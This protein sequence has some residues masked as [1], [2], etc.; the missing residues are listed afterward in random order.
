[1]VRASLTSLFLASDGNR[2]QL[3]VQ[4][5]ELLFTSDLRAFLS[6]IVASHFGYFQAG[7]ISGLVGVL[8]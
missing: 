2:R 8:E 6:V 5:I 3:F 4:F 7:Y 1:M